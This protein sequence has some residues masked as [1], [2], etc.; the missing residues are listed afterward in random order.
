MIGMTSDLNEAHSSHIFSHSKA[1][2]SHP[3]FTL[4]AGT[5]PDPDRRKKF[6]H[7]YGICAYSSVEELLTSTEPD[8]VVLATPTESHSELLRQVLSISKPQAILCEKP[9]SYDINEARSMVDS[10]YNAGCYLFVNFIRRADPAVQEIYRRINTGEILSPLK[11]VAWYSKGLFHNGSHFIDLL[12]YWLGELQET[13]II[14]R[15]TNRLGDPEPDLALSFSRGRV[16]FLCAREEDYSHYTVELLAPNGRLRYDLGGWR[17]IWQPAVTSSTNE[18]YIV[19]DRKEHEI[20]NQMTRIQWHITD[21]LANALNGKEHSLCTGQQA[22]SG[23]E[24]ITSI[25]DM[26]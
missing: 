24:D 4:L 12:K 13:H 14:H 10:C 21:Q 22:L 20:P 6:R 5:D 1:F 8:I 15:G 11:G 17:I 7:T 3:S 19:L 18:G 26:L 16:I 9:L 2:S 23:L 25:K